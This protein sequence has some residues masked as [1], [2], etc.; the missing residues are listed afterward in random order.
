LPSDQP[1]TFTFYH[2]RKNGVSNPRCVFWDLDLR[3]WS[4][5]GCR[6]LSTNNDATECAC[7]HLTSSYIRASTSGGERQFEFRQ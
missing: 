3:E 6:M 1:A 4:T 7:N 2:L 5:D